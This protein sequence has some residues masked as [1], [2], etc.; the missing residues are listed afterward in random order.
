MTHTLIPG[1]PETLAGWAL[2]LLLVVLC[3][4]AIWTIAVVIRQFIRTVI[5]R[6]PPE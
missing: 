3:G 4:I 1:W 2:F 5:R 6:R